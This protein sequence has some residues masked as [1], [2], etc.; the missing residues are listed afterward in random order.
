MSERPRVG[1]PDP[2]R[3]GPERPGEGGGFAD[4]RSTEPSPATATN[5]GAKRQERRA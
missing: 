4:R 5:A 3:A 1:Y 2:Q